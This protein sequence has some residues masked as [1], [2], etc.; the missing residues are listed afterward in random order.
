ME[1][2]QVA[3]LS[4]GKIF[5][6]KDAKSVEHPSTAAENYLRNL[7]EIRA[8][9]DWKKQGAGAIFMGQMDFGAAEPTL[10]LVS[11]LTSMEDGTLLY[12][13]HT[14]DTAGLYTKN[15]ATPADKDGYVLTKR[16]M[17]FF[18]PDAHNGRI[19]LST[20]ES[21]R[22][23]HL[24]VVTS[25]GTDITVCT[26]GEC[27]DAN[28]KWSRAEENVVLYDSCGLG[29]DG[30]MN[31]VQYGPR[32]IYRVNVKTGDLEEVLEGTEK[33]EFLRP[34]ESA[35]GT[36]YCIRRPYKEKARSEMTP[37]DVLFFPVRMLK[38][39]FGWMNFFSQR[40]AGESLKTGGQNP[41]KS[42]QKSEEDLFV[43]GNLVEVEKNLK[44]NTGRGEKNPGYIPSS[45]ELI[46]RRAD[47]KIDVL[48]KGVLDFC[49]EENGYVFSN[50][51]Y[52]LRKKSESESLLGEAK[53][54]ICL[55][56]LPEKEDAK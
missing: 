51:K 9:N 2:K 32:S 45:W 15:P 27:R 55:A 5:S 13:L 8:K 42:K 26:E 43:E 36:L 40:Y 20:G 12:S 4:G 49:M 16:G 19:A 46:A 24:A 50:G 34:Y 7:K 37:L 39:I 21:T 23:R 54:G 44:E 3:C 18:E 17:Q 52:I 25:D 11:G 30:K 47:G 38:A 1:T 56:V 29:F 22:E 41:A 33:A 6:V 31:F 28:P 10:P 53:L 14:G 35:D 48:R